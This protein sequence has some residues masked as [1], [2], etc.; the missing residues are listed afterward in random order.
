MYK[1]VNHF[2]RWKYQASKGTTFAWYPSSSSNSLN[3]G[4]EFKIKKVKVIHLS[5]WTFK[6][7][8]H[9][10]LKYKWSLKDQSLLSKSV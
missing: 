3:F 6:Y 1:F 7:N 8:M 2:K 10:Y 4:V 5:L 9:K